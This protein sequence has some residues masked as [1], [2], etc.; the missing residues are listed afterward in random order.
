MDQLKIEIQCDTPTSEQEFY[1]EAY[2]LLEGVII[3]IISRLD[4]IRNY[5]SIQNGK[6]PVEYCKAR[7][8]SAQSMKEKLNR[9]NL[10]VT[11][12]NA[13]T[14][15]MDAAGI[16][17]VCGFLEDIYWI[18]DMLKNQQDINIIN[19]KDYIRNPKPSGYRSYHVILQVPIHVGDK[20]QLIFCELQIR[21]LAMDCWANL[22]HRLK[23]KKQIPNQDGRESELKCCSEETLTTEL[24]L[25]TIQDMIRE[26]EQEEWDGD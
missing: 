5:K 3:E 12:D 10:E 24:D 23:Y 9:K 18:V 8:K 22:E 7:I 26:V 6:D 13:L 16:R 21:T 4:I 15:V 1:K 20:I 11:L 19:E 17:V 25:Q 2:D 14:Q